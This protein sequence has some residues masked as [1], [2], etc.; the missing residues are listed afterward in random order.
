[1]PPSRN[2]LS[3]DGITLSVPIRWSSVTINRM[4][5]RRDVSWLRSRPVAGVVPDRSASAATQT[6][7]DRAMKLDLLPEI[8]RMMMNQ[9]LSDESD[10]MNT[11]SYVEDLP[12]FA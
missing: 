8:A 12:R 6:V 11:S 1:M 9:T 3:V 5:G 2:S 4:L 10:A 7:A